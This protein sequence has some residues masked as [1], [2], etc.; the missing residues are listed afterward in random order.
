MDVKNWGETQAKEVGP[1]LEK[2][3]QHSVHVIEKLMPR[4]RAKSLGSGK[5]EADCVLTFKFKFPEGE[6]PTVEVEGLVPPTIV[7]CHQY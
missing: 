4:I 7:K 2:T 6:T 5:L 1:L 3:A